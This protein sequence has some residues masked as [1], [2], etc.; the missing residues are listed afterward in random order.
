MRIVYMLTSLGV[1]GTE[2]QVLALGSRMAAKGHTVTIVALRSARPD[3]LATS[4]PVIHLDLT[5]SPMGFIN[6]LL[7]GA[8]CLRA[9]RPHI[10]HSHN[11]PGNILA[12]LL[13]VPC[14]VPALISTIHNSYEGG[15]W[16]MMAYRRTD[17][18][19]TLSTAVSGTTAA[20]FIRLKS[21]PRAKCVV[22]TNGID[23]SEFSPDKMRR[24]ETRAQMGIR[25]EF[26][27]L[28]SGR[29]APAKDYPNMLEAFRLVRQS[30]P[31]AQLWIAGAA[32]QSGEVPVSHASAG[33]ALCGEQ[34]LCLGLRRDIPALLDA[35]DAFV[36]SSA[37]EGMP[38]ALGEAMAMAKPVVATDVGGVR[39][40]VGEAGVIVRAQDSH[41]LAEAMLSVMKQ[42]AEERESTGCIARTRINSYFSMDAKAE[43][44]EKLYNSVLNSINE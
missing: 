4:L 32:A 36:L 34:V 22:L 14:R 3:D 29:I 18:F 26:V 23:A 35:A 7:R 33:E 24:E 20:R 13:R 40:L 28:A 27:W 44:W 30:R 38:L 10:V 12:R 41:D 42:S 15:W 8:K 31:E 5:R 2:R 25:D 19:A 37:W 6:G 1:G 21:V 17:R 9:S 43:E 16:R 11:F 39:E